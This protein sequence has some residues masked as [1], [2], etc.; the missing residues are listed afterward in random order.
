MSP[1]QRDCKRDVHDVALVGG[2]ARIPI[3]Q[4]MIQEF[5]NGKEQRFTELVVL[6]RHTQK[7]GLCDRRDVEEQIS[8][9]PRCEH[10]EHTLDVESRNSV[11][12]VQ[13]F[14][15]DMGVPVS[16]MWESI[17]VL[18][19]ASVKTAKDPDG[20]PYP[21]YPSGKSRD[22]TSHKMGSEKK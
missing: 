8:I 14:A 22:E 13:H 1:R 21:V 2:S 9:S 11:S 3:V 19:Q 4:K 5:F 10:C 18:I 16:K 20:G 7:P 15:A 12:L 6:S 17:E